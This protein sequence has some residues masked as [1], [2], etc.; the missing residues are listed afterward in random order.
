M[1]FLIH[2]NVHLHLITGADDITRN[3]AVL[4]Y[5]GLLTRNELLAYTLQYQRYLETLD[6]IYNYMVNQF[7]VN[8][9][10][11]WIR[12]KRIRNVAIITGCF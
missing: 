9:L 8:P 11:K 2:K 7:Y 4:R 5:S 6:N 3:N 10:D 1:G 12:K